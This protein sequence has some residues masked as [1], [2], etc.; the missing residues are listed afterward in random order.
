M[1]SQEEDPVGT[2][3]FKMILRRGSGEEKKIQSV[4][5]IGRGLKIIYCR[6]EGLSESRSNQT[7]GRSMQDNEGI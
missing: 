6:R 3:K 5:Q 7:S 2:T 4:N 1:S